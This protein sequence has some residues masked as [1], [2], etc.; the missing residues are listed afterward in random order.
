MPR[1]KIL[2]IMFTS[3]DPCVLVSITQIFTSIDFEDPTSLPNEIRGDLQ[4][5]ANVLPM[6]CIGAAYRLHKFN[7]V[8]D[9]SFDW[10]HK[11]KNA[12]NKKGTPRETF[13]SEQNA[14][15]SL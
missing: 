15:Y 9:R 7:F 10:A 3:Q 12:C 14:Y 6:K 2:E 4:M 5:E 8:Q 1:L 11:S 13:T